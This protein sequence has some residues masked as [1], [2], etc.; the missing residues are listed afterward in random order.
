MLSKMQFL[1]VPDALTLVQKYKEEEAEKLYSF[2][3]DDIPNKTN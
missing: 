1:V 3:T 2:S